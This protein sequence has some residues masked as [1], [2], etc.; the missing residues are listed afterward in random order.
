MS[1]EPE[2]PSLEL[3]LAIQ[4]AR[5][6]NVKLLYQQQVSQIKDYCI[7]TCNSA[8][9][10]EIAIPTDCVI[11][12]TGIRGNDLLYRTLNQDITRVYHIG[13]C[14]KSGKIVHAVASGF[15][16]GYHLPG[17]IADELV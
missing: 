8:N 4:Y 11:L 17:K 2:N 14:D 13:D 1:P 7:Y 16:L 10:S 5:R 9:S 3:R 15:E 6:D 12:S